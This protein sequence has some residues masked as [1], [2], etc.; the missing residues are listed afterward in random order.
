MRRRIRSLGIGR[1]SPSGCR[2]RR[3]FEA[4]I[5]AR[6]HLYFKDVPDNTI[7]GV[8][9]NL[10]SEPFKTGTG[11]TVAD[12]NL[13]VSLSVYISTQMT[14]PCSASAGVGNAHCRYRSRQRPRTWPPRPLCTVA[15]RGA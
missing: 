10:R 12:F 4:A 7:R 11:L 1:A 3:S 14:T 6:V 8:I 15:A 5:R 2:F 9:T 13:S